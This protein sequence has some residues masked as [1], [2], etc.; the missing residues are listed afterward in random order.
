MTVSSSTNR[1]SY[2]GNGT[3]TVFA[4]T[5]KVFDEDD[6]T[7]ILRAS[8]GTETVQTITTHYTVS[9]VG[10]AG[11]GNV[12]FVTAPTATET[13]VI[14][15]EQPLTQ[16]L[17][18]VPNDP[19]PAASLEDALDKL[20]F[21]TQQHSEELGRTIKAS[22]T[23]TISG[24]EF[25]ISAANRANKVFA[26]DS[27]GDLSITQELGTN[28]GN[29][30]V[31]TAYNERDL[32]KDT[33]DGSIYI[34][35]TAH[36]SSGAL[37]LDTN[38]NSSY[39]DAIFDVGALLAD[40]LTLSG[41]LTV[42]GNTT[43]GDAAT[44]TVTVTA[45]PTFGTTLLAGT[46]NSF[47]LGT[48]GTRFRNGY[49][50]SSL[51]V[52]SYVYTNYLNVQNT[53]NSN[54]DTNL[55][56]TSS[57][58]ITFNG[59]VNSSID[60][61]ADE[62]Y[63][64]G[65]SDNR[66]N[67]VAAKDV[68][69]TLVYLEGSTEDGFETRLSAVDPTQDNF[70]YFPDDTGTVA[71]LGT[72]Q[73]F[74]A[75]QHFSDRIDIDNDEFIGWGGGSQRPAIRGDKTINELEF[76][77]GGSERVNITNSGLN[78]NGNITATGNATITGNLTVNGT[79]TT[80]A[81]T[82][83]VVSDTLIELGN[84]TT[85]TPAND[86][87]IVIERGDSDNAFIG[88][89]ESTDKFIVGTGTFTGASTGNLTVTS[90]TLVADIEGN[91]TGDVTGNLTGNVTGN[92][93]GN[94]TGN[95]TGNVTGYAT[96]LYIS[97]SVDDDV[98]YNVPFLYGAG[99]SAKAV[100]SDNGGLQFN[101]GAN[102]L[103]VQNITSTGGLIGSVT[104]NV[105]SSGTSTFSGTLTSSGTT[106][107]NNLNITGHINEEVY[108]L[109]GTVI[110]PANGTIQYKTLSANTTFTE[111]IGQGESVTLMIDDGTGYTV[112][113]PTITW[114]NNGGS[115]PTLATTGYT[116]VVLWQVSTTLYGA[117]VG[118]GT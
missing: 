70:I 54:G 110:D 33:T 19:F 40:S 28:R 74:T 94:L 63:A 115:A 65:T 50:G 80:V 21:V 45:Q 99:N 6:L 90:G 109:T 64:L 24:A 88:W 107:V 113:W 47:D 34:V 96:Q 79:T 62:T 87:G 31:S 5:F 72:A 13:V 102:R 69:T 4:Y 38:T 22:K 117:T 97:E 57:D 108:S 44:D 93:T 81:T 51:Y 56:D 43:L 59:Q 86:A 71:L 78:V 25:T 58:T 46:H 118:N 75:E 114:V 61:A 60:P 66:W 10:D 29:W 55:G 20:V 42:S 83:T 73:T 91:V 112:T 3:L 17:D 35:N 100:I 39:Y 84:G 27:S 37:P 15:R 2:S 95:V 103:T 11:G 23:N 53:L 67:W 92:V 14:L 41:D 49:F 77:T 111:S 68:Y 106:N 1:V 48:T 89:D 16:G 9:G 85:G 101:P 82:N 116:V 36:T 26:F 7:V 104:G 18:L 32:V 76:W 52:D 30:A 8:D 105:T 12:T 98:S